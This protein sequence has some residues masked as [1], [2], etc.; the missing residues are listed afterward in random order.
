MG[1]K[2]LLAVVLVAVCAALGGT[3]LRAPLAAAAKPVT[4][5]FVD[6][7]AD[8]PIPVQQQ[9][10]ATVSIE[11]TPTVSVADSREP[12]QKGLNG[13]LSGST[14]SDTEAFTV[15]AGKR[16]VV[17][18]VSVSAAVPPDEGVL[19]GFQADQEIGTIPLESGGLQKTSAGDFVQWAGG[20]PLVAYVGSGKQFS[21]TLD[22]ES[23][24]TTGTTGGGTAFISAFVSGYLVPSP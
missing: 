18:Y 17:Q 14:F 23:S 7:T 1:K 24:T 21:V 12:F 22:R 6:N 11:G 3:V 4:D 13:F 16:L 8:S 20:Q 2:L 19:V 10:T 15:P 9:G 5:V